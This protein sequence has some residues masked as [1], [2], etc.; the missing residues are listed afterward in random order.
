MS[1]G[2]GSSPGDRLLIAFPALVVFN[3]V[4]SP[5]L[6]MPFV[7]SAV[8][9]IITVNK[10]LSKFLNAPERQQ[11]S[12]SGGGDGGE[13]LSLDG[14][15]VSDRPVEAG[16]IAIELVRA[17][18]VNTSTGFNL[19]LLSGDPTRSLRSPSG[20]ALEKQASAELSRWE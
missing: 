11:T 2:M 20:C 13:P 12:L 8:V 15:F 14:H 16:G 9:D 4:T 5:L 18:R 10:R 1:L 6:V 19:V 3:T 7:I 17:C